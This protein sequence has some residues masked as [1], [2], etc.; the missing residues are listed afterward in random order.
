[1]CL[2]QLLADLHKFG[3]N[4]P[5]ASAFEAGDYFSDQASLDPIGFD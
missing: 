5:Q 3:S 4:Q 2:C 1:M